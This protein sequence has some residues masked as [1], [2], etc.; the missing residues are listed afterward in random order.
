[1]AT[2]QADAG[3]AFGLGRPGWGVLGALG[4]VSLLRVYLC[5]QTGLG[6]DEAYYA[7]WSRNLAWNYFDHPPA[8]AG[9]IR[10][11][12]ELFGES[13]QSVRLPAVVLGGLVALQVENRA[14][15]LGVA[16][17]WGLAL[18]LSSP[19]LSLLSCFAIPE[20]ALCF[21]L[22]GGIAEIER[23]RP[24]GVGLALGLAL[25][26][27]LSAGLGIILLA[28]RLVRN[29]GWRRSM[30][31]G[32]LAMLVASPWLVAE[33]SGGA[34]MVG[35][36]MVGRHQMAL[37]GWGSFLAYVVGF[38]VLAGP[39][40]WLGAREAWRR[41]ELQLGL[42]WNAFFAAWALVTRGLPHWGAPGLVW[43]LAGLVTGLGRRG[44]WWALGLGGLISLGSLGQ[45]RL[46]MFSLGPHDPTVDLRGWPQALTAAR[47]AGLVGPWGTSRWQVAGQLAWNLR[48][49]EV[50]RV[51]GN[52]DQWSL[53]GRWDRPA[54]AFV[55]VE[56]SRL[57]QDPRKLS[58]LEGCVLSLSYAQM[59]RTQAEREF[60]FWSCPAK[61]RETPA[62]H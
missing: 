54:D 4:L 41:G 43:S 5:G 11:S 9:L 31:V 62:I 34:R 7:V 16:P 10:L 60:R 21:C 35:F 32:F 29:F 50:W 47:E 25:L 8:I 52:P 55:F 19:L 39:G 26:S 6:D 24:F 61:E 30:W 45:A 44:R 53:W 28:P 38:G 3:L 46:G 37:P 13:A 17:G 23:K 12:T 48:G 49:Q 58:G 59:N 36:Q 56:H 51:G 27:K 15:K 22:M 14:R 2:D 42:L 40:L 1:M 57:S 18:C 20:L 33:L